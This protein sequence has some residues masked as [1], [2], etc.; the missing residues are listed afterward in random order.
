MGTE[1]WGTFGCPPFSLPLLPNLRSL[2]WDVPS[3]IYSYIQWFVTQNL[4]TLNIH[5]GSYEFNLISARTEMISD[6]AILHLSNLPSL[7]ELHIEL[8]H[9]P[10]AAD[11]QKL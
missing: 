5:A 11:T 1:I 9:I 2:T 7:R 3:G 6:A 8:H 10:I 4:T